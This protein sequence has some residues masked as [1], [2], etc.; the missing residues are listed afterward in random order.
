M[1]K[2]YFISNVILS[3]LVCI[4]TTTAYA[5][6]K[7]DATFSTRSYKIK[8]F[9]EIAAFKAAIDVMINMHN[10]SLEKK[11]DCTNAM[12][13]HID[14]IINISIVN[15][16]GF[17]QLI[18]RKKIFSNKELNYC[19]ENPKCTVEKYR[20]QPNHDLTSEKE[21]LTCAFRYIH[22]GLQ[23][24]LQ[25][26]PNLLGDHT[27]KTIPEFINKIAYNIAEPI[28][29]D[30]PV[31]KP[32][33]YSIV[34]APIDDVAHGSNQEVAHKRKMLQAHEFY[35]KARLKQ[36]FKNWRKYLDT[37][38]KDKEIA[39]QFYTKK[40]GQKVM[41]QWKTEMHKQVAA[42]N[43]HERELE[44]VNNEQNLFGS[45]EDHE[46]YA[47]FE[48]DDDETM[49][50]FNE[51][52]DLLYKQSEIDSAI[53]PIISFS[54]FAKLNPLS[55][56]SDDQPDDQN[57]SEEQV[58]SSI[59]TNGIL[60]SHPETT[61]VTL[62][63][64]SSNNAETEK[65]VQALTIK[66]RL[67]HTIKKFE[68]AM[69][70]FERDIEQNYQSA[71][72]LDLVINNYHDLFTTMY[73][74]IYGYLQL[75]G[76][77]KFGEDEK[78][79]LSKFSDVNIDHYFTDA[80][81]ISLKKCL[82]C[83]FNYVYVGLNCL[84]QYYPTLSQDNNCNS[85]LDIMNN[86]ASLCLKDPEFFYVFR[87]T[88]SRK[89][90]SS[91]S[92]QS[93]SFIEERLMKAASEEG[94]SESTKFDIQNSQSQPNAASF[95][96]KIKL[97]T[98]TNQTTP[99]NKVWLRIRLN[100]VRKNII[101]SVRKNDIASLQ[102]LL[103]CSCLACQRSHQHIVALAQQ[104]T[105]AAGNTALHLAAHHGNA[106][107]VAFLLELRFNPLATNKEEKTSRKLA[108]E[109]NHKNIELILLEAEKNYNKEC[110]TANK[111]AMQ[112][113]QALKRKQQ[114]L[115]AQHQKTAELQLLH[116]KKA[117]AALAQK[118]TEKAQKEKLEERLLYQKRLAQAKHEV[119][120]R[121]YFRA[122]VREDDDGS[123]IET[124]LSRGYRLPGQG[125]EIEGRYFTK[126]A[127]ER[128]APDTPEVRRQ[129]EARALA[130]GLAKDTKAFNDYVQ[131]RGITPEQ[132]T[133]TITLGEANSTHREAVIYRRNGLKVVVAQDGAII[134]AV[135][136]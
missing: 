15:I 111:A 102:Q 45:V 100:S 52:K 57:D 83:T 55:D 24:I 118:V 18:C 122:A 48:L 36:T 123:W 87:S 106:D 98:K 30:L 116:R 135:W 17:C 50:S 68:S 110:L 64:L 126:H 69:K 93:A 70:T 133:E 23:P 65:M 3:A 119:E 66:S 56:F 129:L 62:R 105:D 4:I 81:K 90:T 131:P 42:A 134:T 80:S 130:K 99:N 72:S 73:D 125:K 46:T 112:I 41:R 53:L 20:T 71:D 101:Q 79:L 51:E 59:A 38:K 37:F 78:K 67:L 13:R 40:L 27:C 10:K 114:R 6:T 28:D 97:A 89:D 54:S 84:L 113:E 91:H 107:I 47:L 85:I 26:A 121:E 128:M 25:Y 34:G 96:L 49:P 120:L 74:I 2:I 9:D 61:F 92:R 124:I 5:M 43:K 88:K 117:E 108:Q 1:K 12:V 115:N 86:L 58:H 14:N 109:N 21:C 39:D 75:S 103:K 127:L 94:V 77:E 95:T 33:T 104:I 22:D 11:I 16:V 35:T 76:K 31:E 19:K 63:G 60:P 32:P 82:T 132:V 29:E 8:L 7:N 136:E 44:T